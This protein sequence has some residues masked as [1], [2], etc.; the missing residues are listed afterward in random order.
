MNWGEF[1][2]TT[3][4]ALLTVCTFSFLYKDNPFYKFAEAL[5]VGVSAG[6]FTILLI[7][8]GLIPKLIMPIENGKLWYIIP[9]V[10]G[11]LMWFRFSRRLSWISRYPIAFY[12]AIATGTTIPVEMKNRINTQLFT[13]MT[14]PNFNLGLIAGLSDI[15]IIVGLISALIYFFFSKEHKGAF[16]AVAKIGIFTLM[17]GFG[18]SFGYT[19]MARISLFIQR[20]QFLGN[21]WYKVAQ[22]NPGYSAVVWGAALLVALVILLEI[23]RQL[24]KREAQATPQA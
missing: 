7:Y 9:G 16:G 13:S 12:I 24:R 8:T 18:A 3:L 11:V 6:Y 21:D 20:V 15:L 22:G 1:L 23:I 2:W 17:I 10:M 5:V 19:V 14:A 4:A